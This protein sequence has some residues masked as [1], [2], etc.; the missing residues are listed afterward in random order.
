MKQ[1]NSR[2][3]QVFVLEHVRVTF[4][5][6]LLSRKKQL[7][8]TA[9]RIASACS[10]S[11]RSSSPHIL[12]QKCDQPKLKVCLKIPL[13]VPLQRCASHSCR[14]SRRRGR[15]GTP[16]SAC[17]CLPAM[18]HRATDNQRL[19]KSA[20][21]ES[22]QNIGKFRPGRNGHAALD[23]TRLTRL[24]L[25]LRLCSRA[26]IVLWLLAVCAV[27]LPNGWSQNTRTKRS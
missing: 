8:V 15:T 20:N 13:R 3:L 2:G 4:V 22:Q 27:I 23:T 12:R 18:L 19:G 17:D 9:T 11:V 24:E 7:I 1:C 21:D 26:R 10:R 6:K 14:E 25:G 16:P 5:D